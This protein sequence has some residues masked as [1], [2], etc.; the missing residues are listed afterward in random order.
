[1]SWYKGNEKVVGHE[2][3]MPPEIFHSTVRLT[4]NSKW[5]CPECFHVYEVEN[6]HW[7]GGDPYFIEHK[8]GPNDYWYFVGL[9]AR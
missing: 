8:L 3:K 5:Q 4:K 7:W 1:M 9:D 2:C 6:K